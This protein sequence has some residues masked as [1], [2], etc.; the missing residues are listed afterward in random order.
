MTGPTP[1]SPDEAESLG[2]QARRAAAVSLAVAGMVLLAKWA[3]WRLTGSVALMAD[4]MESAVNVVAAMV[5]Y[6][7]LEIARQPEDE[8]HP[9]GH[10]KAEYF[11]AGL[12]GGL[13]AM[14]AAAIV[15]DASGRLGD[16][17][18]LE[19]MRLGLALAGAA[20][21]VNLALG[22]WLRRQGKRLRSPAVSADGAH[23]LADVWTTVAALVGLGVAWATGW[24]WL[25]AVIA[26]GVAAH[27]A[28]MGLGIVREAVDGLMDAALAPTEVQRLEEAIERARGDAIEVHDLRTRR[29]GRTIFL[30]F[31][32]VV[33][34]DETVRASH[35]RCDRLEATLVAQWPDAMVTIHVEPEDEAHGDPG[36]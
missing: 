22:L 11:A 18:A 34:G 10:G 1:S 13:V 5:A 27:V 25:D 30:E 20:G 6:V 12:E 8:G 14:A 19:G 9:W 24:W 17:T 26:L 7:A 33:R 2:L 35:D 29:A 36:G 15:W 4:G 16:A 31:H 28:W 23:V 3:A 32:L 21:V